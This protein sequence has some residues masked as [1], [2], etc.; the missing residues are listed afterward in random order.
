M[1][2]LQAARLRD[3]L[4]DITVHPEKHNQNVWA[5]APD[6]NGKPSAC[7]T[8]GCLAGNAVINAGY[9]LEWY[10]TYTDDDTLRWGTNRVLDKETGERGPAI[11]YVARDLFGL[12]GT[13]ANRLFDSYHTVTDLWEMA[14]EY[15]YGI[16]RLSDAVDAFRQ[17]AD[18][19]VSEFKA[20]VKKTLSELTDKIA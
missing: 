16:I 7:G 11:K 12:T 14:I 6:D 18:L 13:Q 17:R 1:D 8:V 20:E 3:E 5:E 19:E 4:T 10:K 9:Q 15:S 2:Y